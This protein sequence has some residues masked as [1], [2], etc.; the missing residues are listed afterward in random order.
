M[1][2]TKPNK[3]TRGGSTGTKGNNEEG[4]GNDFLS[5]QKIRNSASLKERI[6]YFRIL[7]QKKSIRSKTVTTVQ[8]SNK[9]VQ[10]LNLPKVLNLNPRSIYNKVEE[11]CTFVVEEEI[12][13]VC[14][15]E[16]HERWYLTQNNSKQTLTD[17]I[18][19]DDHIVIS[20]PSQRTGKGG[21][22]AIIVDN[23][24][25]IVHNLTQS[26]I[27]IPWGVEIVWAVLTPLKTTLDSNIQKIIVG[28]LYCKPNSRKKTALLDHIAEVYQQMSTKYSRGLHWIIAGDYNDLKIDSILDISPRFKQVVTKP[29]RL[30]PPRI[31]DKIITTL[32]DFYQEPE[33]L[34]PLD[35]D[36]DKNGSPSDHNIVVMSAINVVN[37]KP[38]RQSRKVTF[39]PITEGGIEKME[40]W[41]KCEELGNCMKGKQVDEKARD[42]MQL[43]LTQVNKFFPEKNRKISNDN[44]P[45]FTEKLA[46][47]KR[48]KQREYNKNRRSAKW[49]AMDLGYKFQLDTAKKYYYKNKIAKFKKYDPKKWYFWLKRLVSSNQLKSH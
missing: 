43:L 17:I 38:G 44:Q 25:Y 20:N 18:Q 40:S 31:L 29:T 46:K 45:F 49:K 10:A 41:L 14:M 7:R 47:A 1:G 4:N 12:D 30:N 8:R 39:R 6:T 9:I 3:T 22:P 15:S 13:L 24:K 26:E 34:P 16:S 2:V 19:I 37:N 48:K 33:I 35:N 21:R 27:I 28:S 11:F 36:P 5:E 32:A 42:M 23:K